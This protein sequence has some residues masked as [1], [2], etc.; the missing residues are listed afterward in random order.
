MI[1]IILLIFLVFILIIDYETFV[2]YSPEYIKKLEYTKLQKQITSKH[3]NHNTKV[4]KMTKHF[5]DTVK[6][7]INS[8]G[9]F[10]NM[11]NLNNKDS[12]GCILFR[13]MAADLTEKIIE[14]EIAG[15]VF[16][17]ETIQNSINKFVEDYEFLL[18]KFYNIPKN[19]IYKTELPKIKDTDNS[20]SF[21][22]KKYYLKNLKDILESV[23]PK[24]D[25][26]DLVL[27]DAHLIKDALL[28]ELYEFNFKD[29]PTTLTA[30]LQ[31]LDMKQ[32]STNKL[33]CP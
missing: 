27:Y 24:F 29:L 5:L 18:Y 13:P 14:D 9:S 23:Y 15:G 11:V 32:C 31:E 30:M 25:S 22:V 33:C 17:K 16:I 4:K 28:K 26:A 12:N 20:N 7:A 19:T 10:L 6:N 2:A 8:T 1:N 21:S 3:D